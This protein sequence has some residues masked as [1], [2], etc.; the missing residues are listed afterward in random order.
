VAK[1]LFV[2]FSVG[3]GLL[4]GFLGKKAFEQI[5][6]LIDSEEP[7]HPQHRE[8]SIPKMLIALAIEGAIFRL[9]KGA[10]D[11]WARRSF[12]RFMGTWPGEEE[13][14]PEAE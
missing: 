12:E 11:H 4:A 2:P 14:E 5:W 10:I 7:P 9:T 1:V 6:G 3:A 13:P 8:I